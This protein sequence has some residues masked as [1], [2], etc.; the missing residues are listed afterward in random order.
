MLRH[1]V[2]IITIFL[3]AKHKEIKFGVRTALTMV[4]RW[5]M[6]YAMLMFKE[7]CEKGVAT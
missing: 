1:V 6:M 3:R 2:L 7:V 5:I 4:W